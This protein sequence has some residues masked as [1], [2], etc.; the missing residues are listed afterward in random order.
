[1]ALEYLCVSV[2]PE[3][4]MLRNQWILSNN[5][6]KPVNARERENINWRKN[7]NSRSKEVKCRLKYLLFQG[8]RGGGGGAGS[9]PGSIKSLSEVKLENLGYNSDR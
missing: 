8:Q 3:A 9:D 6:F 7:L 1:M 4:N 5:L 2:D